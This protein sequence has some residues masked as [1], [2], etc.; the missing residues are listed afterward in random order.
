M[1]LFSV[2]LHDGKLDEEE[3]E[4][5]KYRRLQ[6]TDEYLEEHQGYWQKVGCEKDRD[7]DD[8]LAGENVAEESERERDDSYELSDKFDQTDGKSHRVA[9]RILEELAAIFPKTDGGNA[10]YL[11]NEER[12]DGKDE[13]RGEI[14]VR[15]AQ[16]R[17]VHVFEGANAGNE[18]EHVADEDEEKNGHEKRE[19]AA[20]HFSAFE[21]L[22][23]V[24]VHKPKCFLSESLEAAG[25]HREPASYE[26]CE[27]DEK[28]DHDP[29]RDERVRDGNAKEFAQ[30]FRGYCNV[31]TLFHSRDSSILKTLHPSVD[32]R[33]DPLLPSAKTVLDT[34]HDDDFSFSQIPFE[35]CCDFLRWPVCEF[36][37]RSK[38]D[39]RRQT[40]CSQRARIPFG[41]PIREYLFRTFAGIQTKEALRVE[42]FGKQNMLL[43]RP[44]VSLSYDR[45]ALHLPFRI[46]ERTTGGITNGT[47][48]D[49]ALY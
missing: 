35:P 14:G 48:E 30:L 40:N 13:R 17:L 24:V 45:G 9:D 36:I 1:C 22:R 5:G 4:E 33:G 38:Q 46:K 49:D 8:H 3:R 28:R 15:R 11:D 43:S 26:K 32:L 21:G 47:E 44:Y 41:I 23:H 10:C 20:R 6:E 7:R 2:W 39:E 42:T 19:K 16:E 34:R 18:V 25:D 31:Y 37:F 12:N 27:R 29:A